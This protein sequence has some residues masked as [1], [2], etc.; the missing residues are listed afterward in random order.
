MEL[1]SEGGTWKYVLGIIVFVL[2]VVLVYYT[3]T[4]A[5]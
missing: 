1:E 5:F 3:Y 4:L 2:L